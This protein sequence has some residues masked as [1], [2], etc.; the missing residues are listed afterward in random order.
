MWLGVHATLMTGVRPKVDAFVDWAWDYFSPGRA[1]Q[2]LDRTDAPRIEW[3][4]ESS[5]PSTEEG[6]RA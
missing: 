4:G 3:G 2:S 6:P 1:S 5:T